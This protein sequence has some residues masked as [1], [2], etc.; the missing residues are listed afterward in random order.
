MPKSS[1]EPVSL[2]LLESNWQVEMQ[3][4]ATYKA[5]ASKELD[6][7]RRNVM[8]GLAAAEKYHAGLWAA[9]IATL[10]GAWRLETNECSILQHGV[11][12]GG[13]AACKEE[14]SRRGLVH[15]ENVVGILLTVDDVRAATVARKR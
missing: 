9:E 7:R 6:A 4:H 3:D 1:E 15:P 14:I 8:R 2:A 13:I 11:S 12:A 5:L 10:E